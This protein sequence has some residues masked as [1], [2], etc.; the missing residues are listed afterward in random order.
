ML[1]CSVAYPLDGVRKNFCDITSTIEKRQTCAPRPKED[2]LFINE[3]LD[4]FI[5]QYGPFLCCLR[6]HKECMKSCE[7][8]KA[9]KI[10][11]QYITKFISTGNPLNEKDL[12]DETPLHK[13]C[14][15]GLENIV[16]AL[17]DHGALPNILNGSQETCLDVAIFYDY[18]V[19]IQLLWDKKARCNKKQI[20]P[21]TKPRSLLSMNQLKDCVNLNPPMQVSN[22]ILIQTKIMKSFIDT[23]A[24]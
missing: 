9:T 22:K 17:L 5:I 13:A 1:L 16:T 24:F 6:L 3:V 15:L 23:R 8:N 2:R 18:P 21:I 12:M 10:L 20:T 14:R 7:F 11:M 4:N 19:L